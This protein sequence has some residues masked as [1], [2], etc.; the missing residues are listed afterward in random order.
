MEMAM[1]MAGGLLRNKGGDF[2]WAHGGEGDGAVR[3]LAALLC[4]AAL[5]LTLETRGLHWLW[6]VLSGLHAIP[7]P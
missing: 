4:I 6:S 1:L 7:W 5:V 3:L 2:A